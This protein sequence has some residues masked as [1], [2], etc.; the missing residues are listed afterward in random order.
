MPLQSNNEAVA[1]FCIMELNP[2][3]ALSLLLICL[4]WALSKK[5]VDSTIKRLLNRYLLVTD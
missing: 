2:F 3:F 5:S 4:A 1:G